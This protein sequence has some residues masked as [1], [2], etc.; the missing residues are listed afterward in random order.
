[1]VGGELQRKGCD[2]WRTA[3]EGV[4]WVEKCR[5]RG[6]VGGELLRKGCGGWRTAEEG[7]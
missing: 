1:M 7:V 5:G 3:E 2:G 6:V 4:W